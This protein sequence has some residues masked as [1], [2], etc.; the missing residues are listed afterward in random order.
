MDR[1]RGLPYGPDHGLP[2][3]SPSTDHPQNRTKIINKDC[4]YGLS[5]T[6]YSCQ[7]NFECFTLCK[8]NRPGFLRKKKTSE[9]CFQRK[10][11]PMAKRRKVL[12]FH[13]WLNLAMEDVFLVF[14]SVIPL[15]KLWSLERVR[16]PTAEWAEQNGRGERAQI[17]RLPGLSYTVWPQQKWYNLRPSLNPSPL[18]LHNNV[19]NFADTSN[20]QLTRR[21]QFRH[22]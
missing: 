11:M 3:R 7:W 4:T 9:N 8:C 16:G 14:V 5:I 10:E 18:H 15:S 21:C 6:D 20:L 12:T 19:R 22:L 2:L 1:V 17:S 13:S